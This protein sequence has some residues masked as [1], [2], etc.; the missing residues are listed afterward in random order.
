[1]A[2]TT[3]AQ[4][5]HYYPS[6]FLL[7]CSTCP[8]VLSPKEAIPHLK[9]HISEYEIGKNGYRDLFKN[10][11]LKTMAKSHAIIRDNEP[12]PPIFGIQPFQGYFCPETN[13]SE[14]F[15]TMSQIQR[16]LSI[17]HGLPRSHSY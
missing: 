11:E 17:D 9:S 14:L 8:K 16:H 12:I 2:S 4:I 7:V 10:L 15:V 1:M 6:Y 3:I 5:F 13:C